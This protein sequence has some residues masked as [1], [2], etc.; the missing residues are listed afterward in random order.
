MPFKKDEK[1]LDE[2][3]L[4]L[5]EPRLDFGMRLRRKDLFSHLRHPEGSVMSRLQQ[6]FGI[7][8]GLS[9]LKSAHVL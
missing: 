2:I 5:H 8:N 6:L 1:I 9:S 3:L 7:E 4:P